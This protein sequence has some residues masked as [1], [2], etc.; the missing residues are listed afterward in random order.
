MKFFPLIEQARIQAHVLGPL[1][2]TLQPG[3]R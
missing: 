3:V 1:V 2:R